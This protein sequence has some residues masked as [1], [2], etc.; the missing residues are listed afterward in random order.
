MDDPKPAPRVEAQQKQRD[1]QPCPQ[2]GEP[3][4]AVCGRRDAIC[5]NCG[6]KESCCF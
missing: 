3:M 1:L 4:P 2:C 5:V 6:Y